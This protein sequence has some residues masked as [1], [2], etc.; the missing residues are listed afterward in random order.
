MELSHNYLVKNEE[1]V[2]MGW[3]VVHVHSNSIGMKMK[4]ITRTRM[5]R[6]I[7]LDRMIKK[8]EYP[9]CSSFARHLAEENG[10]GTPPDRKTILRDIEFLRDQLDAP[11]EYDNS[12]KGYYYTD[13]SWSFPMLELNEAELLQLLLAEEMAKSFAG[14]PIA[15]SID[16]LFEKIFFNLSEK[17]EI[18]PLIVRKQFSFYGHPVRKI[19]IKVWGKIFHSLRDNR[20]AVIHYH[21]IQDEQA[22]ERKVEPIH[23]GCVDGEWYLVAFCQKR[24]ELRH[25]AV[26]RIEKIKVTE[27]CFEPYDFEPDEYFSNRFGRFTGKAGEEQW[28]AVKFVPEAVPWILE[29]EWHHKQKTTQHRDGSLTLE[30][31]IPSLFEARRWVLQWGCEA[32]VV[33]PVELKEMIA[34]E[35]ALMSDKYS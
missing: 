30:L 33:K 23:L 27:H 18:D 6:M 5:W 34:S 7:E 11:I 35:I 1:Y 2:S 8:G 26:S 32:E 10:M 28:V 21:G 29:R 25:F 20:I 13:R 15:K 12:K 24:N 31:P 3:L 14:T 16:S 4:N 22:E 17:T 9:N 19:D